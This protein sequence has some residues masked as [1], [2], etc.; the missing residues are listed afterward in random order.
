MAVAGRASSFQAKGDS[1]V[2]LVIGVV[3]YRPGLF[4]VAFGHT[5]VPARGQWI[6]GVKSIA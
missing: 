6:E 1:C 2:P 4:S 5:P 3:L